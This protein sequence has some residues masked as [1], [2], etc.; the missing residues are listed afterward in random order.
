[1]VSKKS[2]FSILLASTMMTPA[3]VIPVYAEQ[4]S[5]VDGT[6]EVNFFTY[7]TGTTETSGMAN[8]FAQPAKLIVDNGK[9]K[10]QLKIVTQNSMLGT[11]KVP[12]DGKTIEMT[13]IE[14]SVETETRTVEIPIDQFNKPIPTEVEVI[15]PG[16][17]TAVKQMFDLIV[18]SPV[19]EALAEQVAITAYKWNS[20][21]PSLMQQFLV[22]T[23]KILLDKTQTIV[24]IA[25]TNKDYVNG[26]MI[27]GKPA[28]IVAQDGKTVTY[29]ATVS[30]TKQLLEAEIAVNANG[31]PMTQKAH[32]HLA[33]KGA[34]VM[35]TNPFSDITGYENEAAILNLLNKGIVK[36][37]DKFYPNQTLTRSQFALMIA[38]TLNLSDVSDAGFKDIERF[39]ATNIETYNAINALAQAGIVMKQEKFNP[40]D[41]I[42][43]QHA[44]L[45][46]YRAMQ[47]HVGTDALDFGNNISIY[48]DAALVKGEEEQRALSFLYASGAMTGSFDKNGNRIIQPNVALTR[49][50]MAKILNGTLKYL[51]H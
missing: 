51:G 44:A 7:K 39:K 10:L 41:Y 45:M 2:M 17:T 31:I 9:A 46:I 26:L 23:A 49:G 12:Y 14:G 43:R 40:N 21:E 20:T 28:E 47:Y 18:Q 35:I 32:L 42:T 22:P 3:F 19:E 6:Y 29:A 48:Y 38:R 11:L 25:F 34:P 36:S 15:F 37:A 30:N 1:M 27:N 8:R 4:A 33:V 13:T 50:H 5:I 24:H 16:S